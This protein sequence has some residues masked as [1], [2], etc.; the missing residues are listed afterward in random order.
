MQPW[1]AKEISFKVIKKYFTYFSL[2]SW[3]ELVQMSMNCKCVYIY[4]C[5]HIDCDTIT[6]QHAWTAP[7]IS[8]VLVSVLSVHGHLRPRFALQSG[9]VCGSQWTT[10]RRLQSS[11]Q[12]PYQRGLP[13]PRRLPQ[14]TRYK[15]Q[16]HNRVS[17]SADYCPHKSASSLKQN[18]IQ[19]EDL[20]QGLHIL[21]DSD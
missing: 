3:R 20:K 4:M 21:F 13:G 7:C 19:Y 1:W 6:Y 2:H 12:T 14:T 10:Y 16:T 17:Y 11:P 8:C 15:Q 18:L 9:A 5:A